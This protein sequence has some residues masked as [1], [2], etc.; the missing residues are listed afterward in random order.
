M[1]NGRAMASDPLFARH[2]YK[3]ADTFWDYDEVDN[4]DELSPE[5]T[6]TFIAFLSTDAKGPGLDPHP[7]TSYLGTVWSTF[8]PWSFS[9]NYPS[10][11]FS[12]P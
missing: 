9:P 3:D 7:S 2:T 12:I 1:I 8:L 4:M 10:P 5:L 6:P 11:K